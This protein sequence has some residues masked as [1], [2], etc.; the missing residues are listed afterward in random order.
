MLDTLLAAL[1]ADPRF[2]RNVTAWQTLPARE[3]GYG[4]WPDV[5]AEL[6][7]AGRARGIAQLYTHQERT[8]TAALAGQNAIMATSTA[9]GK[10]LGYTLPVLDTLLRDPTAT[11][12]LIFPTKALAH[13]QIA[14]LERWIASIQ[15]PIALRPYDGDTSTHHRAAI[16]KEARILVTNPDMLHLGILPHHPQ[17]MRFFSGLRYVVLDELH[18]YRGVFGSHVA[19]VLRRLRRVARFYGAHPQFIAASATIANPQALAESLWEAPV[20]AIEDDAAPTGVRHVLFYNP[21]LLNPTLGLRA[22]ASAEA[23]SLAVKLLRT[24]VQTIVFARARISVE[25]LLRE[26]RERAGQAGFSPDAI[27][28]YR[29]GYLPHE[30]RT[31]EQGLRTGQVRI[32]VA[33]NALELG[34][35]IGALDAAILVGYPGSIAATRQQ[36][37]RAGRRA[38]TS[39]AVFIATP[40]P[41]DQYLVTH[42]EYFFDRSPEAARVAPD[43]LSL[44][45]SHLA[46]AAFE[47]PFAQGEPFGNYAEA[48]ALLEFLAEEGVLHRGSDRFTWVSDGY[49]AQGISLRSATPD[50][51]VIKAIDG[52][53]IGTLDRLSA[54]R[55]VHTGAV[56]FHAAE[57]YLIESLDWEQGLALARPA[58]LDYYT[59]AS[60]TSKV[61]RLAARQTVP[62]RADAGAPA[63]G[64]LTDEEVLVHTHTVAYRRVNQDTHETLGW[65]EIALPEMLLE[66]EAF[67]LTLSEPVVEALAD[68]GVLVA[69]LDYGPDWPRIREEILARDMR[70]C[71][72]CGA[73]AHPDHSLEVH[74][75]TPLRVFLSQHPRQAALKL[76]HAPENLITLC[77]T[78]HRQIERANGARTAL[79]GLAYLLNNLA[80][81]FLMCDPGDL[82]TSVEAR[83]AESRLPAVI[84]YDAVPGGVGLSP[85]LVELWESLAQAALERV[86]DCSCF[87]GCPSCVG[88]AGE[89]ESGAKEATRLLLET[90]RGRDC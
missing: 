36:M 30:R 17:W 26:L 62:L 27:Q 24:G 19:N 69:P 42:P 40:T 10:T 8:V 45:T 1:R 41:L 46:C 55:L 20:T 18:T 47:L 88:P 59:I 83:D 82:G 61:E 85:R 65:G 37:G 15:A 71:R 49:P 14:A 51:V 81:V 67:R 74:H 32:V 54:P 6:A 64:T 9:S 11:A 79:G 4:P 35:D 28:G 80:P 33:T 50:N 38:G 70:R 5:A 29:G 78:C 53:V 21:P 43:T 66:T 34:I 89:A 3:A 87:S 48:G 68:I 75:L 13:D 58:D 44:L 7:T 25:L 77:P 22:S 23:L 57:S 12:L 90:L 52:G 39:L 60:T 31:I 86:R 72:I 16:R 56:Y 63:P 2:V 76:A 73:V 84:V